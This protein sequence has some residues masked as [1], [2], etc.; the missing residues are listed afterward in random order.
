VRISAAIRADQRSLQGPVAGGGNEVD[1][2]RL[3]HDGLRPAPAEAEPR[4]R[5]AELGRGGHVQV[6]RETQLDGSAAAPDRQ[7]KGAGP[8][9]P[10]RGSRFHE[11]IQRRQP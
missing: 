9:P 4:H 3:D 7:I 6:T 10:P 1:S 8:K 11:P 2:A 5:L